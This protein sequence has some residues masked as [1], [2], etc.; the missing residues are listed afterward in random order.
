MAFVGKGVTY[1]S[2]GLTIKPG[3]SMATM[4]YDMGGAAAVIAA[5]FAIAEL[6]AAGA[7]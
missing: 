6:R 4:K 7:R 3:S 5:T 2:G 1:D